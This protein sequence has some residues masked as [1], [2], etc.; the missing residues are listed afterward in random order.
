MAVNVMSVL[1]SM[2]FL[3]EKIALRALRPALHQFMPKQRV[4]KESV[5][6]KWVSDRP[7]SAPNCRRN[8]SAAVRV[9]SAR[10][11]VGFL[12]ISAVAT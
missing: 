9:A 2:C 8:R 7:I 1:R 5:S 12:F 11:R 6:D 3:R 10:G 4:T